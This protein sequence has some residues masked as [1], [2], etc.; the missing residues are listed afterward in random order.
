MRPNFTL[1][2]GHVVQLGPPDPNNSWARVELWRWQYG[3]LP[4]PDDNRPL[5]ESAGL[6]AMADAFNTGHVEGKNEW[7]APFNV[8][9][10]MRYC[11]HRLDQVEQAKLKIEKLMRGAHKEQDKIIYRNIL[12]IIN[13]P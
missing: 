7:P 10:V 11:A 13:E 6:R 5:D 8:Q 12:S 9:S 3:E 1:P 4:S 2:S